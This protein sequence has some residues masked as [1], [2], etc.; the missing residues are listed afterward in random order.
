MSLA[1]TCRGFRCRPFGIWGLGGLGSPFVGIIVPPPPHIIIP[2]VGTV[3]IRGTSQGVGYRV[4]GVGFKAYT[5]SHPKD[6]ALS[7]PNFEPSL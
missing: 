2:I 1:W 7:P 4:R 5:P 6:S 3:S